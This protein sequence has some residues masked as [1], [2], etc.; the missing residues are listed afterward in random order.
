MDRGAWRA[1]VPGVTKG[2]TRLKRLSTHALLY[3]V[4]P[5]GQRFLLMLLLILITHVSHVLKVC[6]TLMGAP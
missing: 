6:I 1:T 2:A 5:S 3:I 4:N